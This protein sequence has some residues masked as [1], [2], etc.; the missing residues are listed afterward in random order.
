MIPLRSH[1]KFLLFNLG[2]RILD[3]FKIRIHENTLTLISQA[4]RE[5]QWSQRYSLLE[6]FDLNSGELLGSIELA[7]E[8]TLYATRFD[9][10]FA[11]IVTFLQTDPLFIIDL[12]KP[13]NPVLLSELIVPGWSE[14][15]QVEKD[16]LFAV[17][18]EENRVTASVFN[19][20]D[21]TNPSLAQRIYMGD[22]DEYSWSEANYDEKAIGQVSSRSL[23]HS[24][25][26]ME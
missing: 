6:N 20:S 11:Y 3:K 2:G 5:N 10:D 7:D 14:Y 25:S 4:Y 13:T 24:I 8:E 23:F 17:G 18:I 16:Y 19:I 1:G 22:K 9:G 12:S 15:L 26:N 21:K